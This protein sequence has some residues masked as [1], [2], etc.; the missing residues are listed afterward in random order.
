MI[1]L[2]KMD[3]NFFDEKYKLHLQ[4]NFEIIEQELNSSNLND[5][6]GSKTEDVQESLKQLEEELTQKIKRVTLGVDEPTVKEVVIQVLKEQ[7]VI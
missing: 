1:K 5:T 6:T 4:E 3:D 7:G 2:N